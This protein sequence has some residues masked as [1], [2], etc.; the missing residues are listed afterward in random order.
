MKAGKQHLVPLSAPALV[1]LKRMLV[2]NEC[3]T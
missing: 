2:N 1:I 3:V